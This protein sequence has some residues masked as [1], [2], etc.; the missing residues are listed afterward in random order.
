MSSRARRGKSLALYCK[1][2]LLDAADVW[3]LL[4]P[5]AGPIFDFLLVFFSDIVAGTMIEGKADLSIDSS[6]KISS[7]KKLAFNAKQDLPDI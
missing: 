2:V 1:V 3:E 4:L 7:V 5:F 6:E